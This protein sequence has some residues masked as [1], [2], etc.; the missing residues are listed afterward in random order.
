VG[1]SPNANHAL[2]VAD[3]L[4]SASSL[5]GARYHLA[6]EGAAGGRPEDDDDD[7]EEEEVDTFDDDDGPAEDEAWE[8]EEAV[9]GTPYNGDC[10]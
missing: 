10:W 8:Y 3:I 9:E 1:Y 5:P 6:L 4:A 2:V 7:D